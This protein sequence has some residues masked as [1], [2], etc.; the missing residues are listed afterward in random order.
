[1]TMAKGKLIDAMESS[2]FIRGMDP[3][4]HDD[5]CYNIFVFDPS[6]GCDSPLEPEFFLFKIQP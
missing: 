1:M 2:I 6:Q 5:P 4:D 3:L